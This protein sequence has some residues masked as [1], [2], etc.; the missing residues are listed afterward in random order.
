L[1]NAS[2]IT[3]GRYVHVPGGVQVWSD[4][5]YQVPSG[6]EIVG[7]DDGTH[8][9]RLSTGGVKNLPPCSK[10]AIRNNLGRRIKNDIAPGWQIWAEIVDANNQ[11]TKFIGNFTVPTA[12]TAGTWTSGE[13]IVYLFTSL[14]GTPTEEDIIQPVL[15][16]GTTPAGGGAYWG[17]ASWYVTSLG[18]AVH[19]QV[20]N[21]STSGVI[22]GNMTQVGPTAWYI[23]G[24]VDG[25]HTNITVNKP[26]TLKAVPDAYC[27]LEAYGIQQCNWFPPAGS[28]CAFSEMVLTDIHGGV[29]QAWQPS[30]SPG[31]N[32]QVNIQDIST[33]S[34][35]F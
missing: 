11:F 25:V 20:I 32:L 18:V 9:V 15:Q 8:L 26:T 19:S 27:T 13:T 24:V 31:C 1:A 6:S 16:Y 5:V 30:Q 35:N 21:A 29:S 3:G 17:L 28:S 22:F 2:T 14:V 23:D 7:T 34:I 4:C 33:L 12:P 10:P